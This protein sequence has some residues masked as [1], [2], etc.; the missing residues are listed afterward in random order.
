MSNDL[1]KK[2][3][4]NSIYAGV[5]QE[6]LNTFA[7]GPVLV[8][9]ALMFG[10]SPIAIGFL[11]SLEFFGWFSHFVSSY[12]LNKGKSV[13]S[14]CVRYAAV[15]RIFY[16]FAALLAFFH[17]THWAL[18]IL[19]FCF[20]ANYL[21]GG[22]S[23]GA[24]YPWM[25]S[26]VPKKLLA[27]F[28]AKR[29]RFM[30]IANLV[31]YA[32]AGAIIYLFENYFPDKVIYG[33]SVLLMLAF[34]LGIFSVY[35]LTQIQAVQLKHLNS[36][37]FLK[38]CIDSFKNKIF[39]LLCFFLF[40]LNFAVSFVTPFFTVFMLKSIGIA[41]PLVVF[42]TILSQVSYIFSTSLWTKLVCRIGYFEI[43]SLASILYTISILFFIGTNVQI[44]LSL[45]FAHIILGIARFGVK[46]ATNNIPLL[47][48]PHQDASIYLSVVN[49]FRALGASVSGILAGLTLTGLEKSSISLTECWN[50][51]WFVG[52][53]FFILSV[54]FC[55]KIKGYVLC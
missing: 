27:S 2:S 16:L 8:A 13:K 33:Y 36:R 50:I 47:Y 7:C 34:L 12:L 11:G 25:K 44:I 10:A 19:L 48:V 31:C 14:I 32:F 4:S 15:S 22:V 23:G 17:S 37:T 52:I 41:M 26:L 29:Y 21:I 51:F 55:R 5:A 49:F 30:M 9:Y 6:A 45:L 20:S 53:F 46:L 43:L 24:F 1:L 38:K 42:L 40:L 35:T 3:L 18:W 54:Y 39:I 28:F